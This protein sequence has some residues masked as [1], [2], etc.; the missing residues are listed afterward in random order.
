MKRFERNSATIRQKG[1]I[2]GASPNWFFIF[3]IKSFKPQCSE[4][5]MLQL[6]TKKIKLKFW[7][8]I[9]LKMSTIAAEVSTSASFQQHGNF[10]FSGVSSSPGSSVG[11]YQSLPPQYFYC[12]MH[13]ISS[14]AAPVQSSPLWSGWLSKQSR[15]L[16]KGG[17][18]GKQ[19]QK[20]MFQLF[21]VLDSSPA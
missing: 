3:I 4:I 17:L 18:S 12:A 11:C 15:G 7:F 5:P 16:R 19:W 8:I 9:Q 21:K 2:A 20:R 6:S 10:L 13:E 14:S 1:R